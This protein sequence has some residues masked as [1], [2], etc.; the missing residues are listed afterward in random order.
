[1][2]VN[3][4]DRKS[5]VRDKHGDFNKITFK[6]QECTEYEINANYIKKAQLKD[7]AL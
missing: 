7:S 3:E 5:H 4:F 6:E 1:M 2:R